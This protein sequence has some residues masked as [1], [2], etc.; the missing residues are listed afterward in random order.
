MVTNV[1]QFYRENSDR[2][3]SI[4]KNENG[5]IIFIN[6]NEGNNYLSFLD[7]VGG[8]NNKLLTNF[9]YEVVGLL[10]VNFPNEEELIDNIITLWCKAWDGI[11]GE[12]YITHNIR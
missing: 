3:I 4:G 11:V 8:L 6:F 1:K 12:E 5:T 9:Y 2:W 10:I 7:E